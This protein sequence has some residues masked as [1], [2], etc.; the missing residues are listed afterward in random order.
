MGD[1]FAG[2]GLKCGVSLL[3]SMIDAELSLSLAQLGLHQQQQPHHTSTVGQDQSPEE[4]LREGD[5]PDD[6]ARQLGY[7]PSER[8]L[9][10][11]PEVQ[12][13]RR[14]FRLMAC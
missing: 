11:P 12:A 14:S 6:G 9:C 3:N 2:A 7:P 13:R 10:C 8:D 1:V 4:R 5:P